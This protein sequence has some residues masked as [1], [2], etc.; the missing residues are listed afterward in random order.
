MSYLGTPL[1]EPKDYCPA[2]LPGFM[3]RLR[4]KCGAEFWGKPHA[5]AGGDE[6]GVQNR[7]KA[8]IGHTQNDLEC[9]VVMVTPE[10]ANFTRCLPVELFPD[11]RFWL[12]RDIMASTGE[13]GGETSSIN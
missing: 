9:N 13:D 10:N 5:I 8:A 11:G 1:D 3:W 4:A 2:C 7:T 6:S 12:A